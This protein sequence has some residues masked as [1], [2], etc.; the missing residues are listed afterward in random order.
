MRQE[1]A[2]R[3]AMRAAKGALRTLA[4]LAVI[5]ADICAFGWLLRVAQRP[6]E[7]DIVLLITVTAV[8]FIATFA[9]DASRGT[10]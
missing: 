7:F 3:R 5:G 8:L 1:R 10:P 4:W 6:S 2:I 9:L